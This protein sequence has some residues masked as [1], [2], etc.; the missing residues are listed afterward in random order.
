M[1]GMTNA[2]NFADI[3][4]D[5]NSDINRD[6]NSDFNIEELTVHQNQNRQYMVP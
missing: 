6:E 3:N 1:R 5:E 2:P 4:R